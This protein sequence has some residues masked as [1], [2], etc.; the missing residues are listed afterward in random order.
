MMVSRGRRRGL[1]EKYEEGEKFEVR[2]I[3]DRVRLHPDGKSRT[4][5]LTRRISDVLLAILAAE[6]RGLEG[7]E[8]VAKKNDSTRFQDRRV[9]TV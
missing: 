5:C 4:R 7:S 2:L 8:G 1:V 9:T 6:A 3:G